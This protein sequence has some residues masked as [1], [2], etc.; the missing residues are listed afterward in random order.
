MNTETTVDRRTVLK[1]GAALIVGFYLPAR[2]RAGKRSVHGP[3][4]FEA[5]AWIAVSADD[6]ITLLTEIPEMG[7]GTRTADA[8]M[9]ADELEADWPTIRVEQAPTI[10][11]VYKH[12]GTG[13]SGG[14]TGTWMPMRQAG[15]QAREMLLTAAA[16]QWSVPKG[17]CQASNG[18]IIHLPTGRQLRYGE[19]VEAASRLPAVRLDQI[20]LKDPR[21]YRFIGKPIARVDVP[22]KVGG[23]AAFGTDVR[24]PGMLFAVIARCPHFG[25]ELATCDDSIA[26]TVPGVRRI[27]RVPPIGFTRL[28][29]EVGRNLNV[30][31]GVAVVADSTWAAIQGRKALKLTWNKGPG[32]LES[33]Q[34]LRAQFRPLAA[35]P[36]TVV[37][38]DRGDALQVL[39]HAGKRVEAEYELPFQAHAT[40][41]PMNATAHV[42]D[43]GRIEV[44]S[45]TQI[46][47]PRPSSP[48][49]TQTEIAA[50]AK[51]PPDHV[52]VH[53][54][55][56]GGSFGRRYQW[57]YTAEAWQ[58]A[59]EMRVPV[60]VLWT[61]ED[62]MQHDFYRQYSYQ[63]MSGVLDDRGNIVAWARRLVS[64]PIRSVFDSAESLKDP[65]NVASQEMDSSDS[66][67]YQV[68]NYLLDYAPV[69]SVVPR[70]WWRSVSSSFE[71]FAI[72]CF[73]DELAHAAG[74]DPYQFRLRNL[75]PDRPENSRKLRGV[76]ELAANRSGWGQPLPPGHGRGIAC[77]QF[78]GTYVAQVAEVS[79]GK[80]VGLQVNRVVA[81]VDC[82]F[83]VNPNNVC[84]LIEGGINYALT[85]VLSGEITIKGGAVEQNNFHDYKVLRM[86]DAPE[87]EVHIVPG[88]TDPADGV[89]E[90][91]VP[92]LAPAVANAIFAAT[93]VRL[94]RLPIDTRLFET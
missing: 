19:L 88:G 55:F 15:A 93:R 22:S 49:A 76:L 40:M 71:A 68:S 17:E 89:G 72:E 56:S 52:T 62:D 80:S 51:V 50:L 84:A 60:Q 4:T 2:A 74:A 67:P 6:R 28:T 58:V 13:G 16:N 26:R 35:G 24:I 65:E 33:T 53:T 27:F 47:G 54:M 1:S 46:P 34:S 73:I 37:S 5:N 10:P 18:R 44:W 9:L 3:Q 83:S 70:A 91:G 90:A 77:Y 30:A 85:P 59:N 48:A 63:R 78:A 94:R 32:A 11:D 21:S 41:E 42:R 14:T 31:G 69:N 12:L 36:P 82:G 8:M 86:A 25:G 64:T 92:P 57:D 66:L 20:P 61:R 29:A 81:A 43:D 79:F 45:P 75:R 23:T 39:E 87:I 7:Q 38:V